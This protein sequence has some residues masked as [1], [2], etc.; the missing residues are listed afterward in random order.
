MHVAVCVLMDR[1]LPWFM[2][3]EDRNL[4]EDKLYGL[5]KLFYRMFLISTKT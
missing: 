2:L 5:Q 4:L 3:P 1:K